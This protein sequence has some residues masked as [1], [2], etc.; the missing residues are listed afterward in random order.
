MNIK[1]LLC[2]SL[3]FTSAFPVP[4]SKGKQPIASHTCSIC[5]EKTDTKRVVILSCAHKHCHAC[6]N[7]VLEEALI[8]KSFLPLRCPDCRHEFELADI[9][10]IATEEQ[11]ERLEKLFLEPQE[12]PT[13]SC[14]SHT[15]RPPEPEE[16]ANLDRCPKCG[17]LILKDGGCNVVR[18]TMCKK[19]FIFKAPPKKPRRST[20]S[21]F[22]KRP[23][24]D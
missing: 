10:K 8:R 16:E 2:I 19:K 6:I 3:I 1:R 21:S 5:L 12:E 22:K 17:V 20:N 15:G 11:L 23:W 7:R 9:L 4:G 18:C 13:S 24:K 14:S